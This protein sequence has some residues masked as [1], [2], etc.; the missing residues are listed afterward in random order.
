MGWELHMWR[1]IVQQEGWLVNNH[2]NVS[3]LPRRQMNS[4]ERLSISLQIDVRYVDFRIACTVE[5]TLW[6]PPF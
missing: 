1:Y 4:K 6:K 5:C 3:S 2:G